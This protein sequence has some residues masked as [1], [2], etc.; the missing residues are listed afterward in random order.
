MQGGLF[1]SLVRALNEIGVADAMGNTD[2]PIYVL[3]VVYPLV[4]DQLLEFVSNK[5][6][7]LVL[8]EGQPEYIEQEIGMILRRADSDVIL[9]GKD[10]LPMAGEYTAE[11]IAAG[12][13]KFIRQ[14]LPEVGN[15]L[16]DLGLQRGSYG[17]EAAGR[18]A[19]AGTLCHHGHRAF[20]PAAR[21]APSL[22][23]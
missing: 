13:G 1:N 10:F 20:V 11:V 9:A 6:A 3:N 16:K 21:N 4:P 2:I 5:H 15:Q 18:A 8:E 22:L 23:R 12:V 17:T 14:H 7:V 19:V